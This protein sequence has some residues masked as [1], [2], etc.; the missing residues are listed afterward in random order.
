[1]IASKQGI[2]NR[3]LG[4]TGVTTK[5]ENLQADSVLSPDVSADNYLINGGFDFWQRGVGPL[6]M[7]SSGVYLADRWWGYISAGTETMEKVTS[8]G[9]NS[10]KIVGKNSANGI[11]IGQ[12]LETLNSIRLRSNYVT[13][14][15]YLK[16]DSTFS[17]DMTILLRTQTGAELR[18]ANS[19]GIINTVAQISNADIPTSYEKRFYVTAFV[20]A[21]ATQILVQIN[22]STTIAN[23]SYVEISD[24]VLNQGTKPAQFVRAG[25]TIGQ[26][27]ALCQRYFVKSFP[28]DTAPANNATA[29]GAVAGGVFISGAT[30]ASYALR[31][32]I[33][34]RT[35]P[36]NFTLYTPLSASSGCWYN[37][38]RGLI[39][40][41]G[42]HGNINDA[43]LTINNPQVAGD[44]AGQQV[45]IH[46]S[47]DAEI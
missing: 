45:L 21:N 30:N 34:M 37:N 28:V 33:T 3:I 15:V 39:S 16:R 42:S 43:G 32:P 17:S 40:G 11:A 24:A 6:V 18:F 8:N 25:K 4:R 31:F 38:N 35:Q 36:T 47:A 23:N 22:I 27:L 12:P 7:G 41:V 44:V 19:G 9:K 13:F 5:L 10:L 26:E 46:Y 14:S 29:T 1:M 2:L 20:P